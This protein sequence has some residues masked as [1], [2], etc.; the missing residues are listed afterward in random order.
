M[1]KQDINNNIKKAIVR[2]L[3]Q[4]D[5]GDHFRQIFNKVHYLHGKR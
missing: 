2:L 3:E 4:I 5:N 1:N